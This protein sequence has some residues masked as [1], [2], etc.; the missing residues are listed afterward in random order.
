MKK[1]RCN[2]VLGGVVGLIGVYMIASYA[3]LNPPTLSGVAF[4]IIAVALWRTK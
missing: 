2:Q 3:G 1:L 4:V